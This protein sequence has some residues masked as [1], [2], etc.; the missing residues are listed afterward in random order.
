ST[1]CRGWD[2]QQSVRVRCRLGLNDPPTAVG[3]IAQKADAHPKEKAILVWQYG[4]LIQV[5]RK[6]L[7]AA[8]GR[9]CGAPIG[10]ACLRAP[11]IYGPGLYDTNSVAR[12]VLDNALG[13]E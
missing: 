2:S 12:Y 1:H 6:E 13:T 4:K 11:S 5:L 7:T 3:G 8:L 10:D 9:R